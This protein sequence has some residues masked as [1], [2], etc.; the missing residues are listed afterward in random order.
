M[1]M[2]FL[3]A[4]VMGLGNLLNNCASAYLQEHLLLSAL[5]AL[6]MSCVCFCDAIFVGG[7][8]NELL[9]EPVNVIE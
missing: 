1:V 4:R 6:C 8:R 3:I 7:S 9:C 5:Y 2:L